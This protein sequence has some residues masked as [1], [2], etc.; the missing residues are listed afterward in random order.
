ME[1]ENLKKKENAKNGWIL[2]VD[3]EYPVELHQEHNSYPLAPEKKVVKKS[4]YQKSL[5][6][7]LKLKLADSAKL[8][9]TLQDENNCVLHYQNLQFYLKRGIKLKR[10][11]RV[12][13]FKQECWMESYIRMNTEFRKNARSGFDK[14]FYNLMNN[15]VF[16]KTM[17]KLRNRVDI[18]IVRSKEMDIIRRLV[19]S[20]LYLRHVTFTND[21][22]GIDMRKSKLFLKKIR[23]HRDDDPRQQQDSDVRLFLQ[24]A[25]K[26]IRPKV[27]ALVHRH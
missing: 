25:E 17:A 9:L 3:L 5:L 4:D 22:V 2:Q 15:S 21:L 6:N 1:E 27:R 20:P 24:Q 14:N 26:A 19:A 8:L 12:L 7:D 10:A 18:K 16:G 13:E 11:H 23:L